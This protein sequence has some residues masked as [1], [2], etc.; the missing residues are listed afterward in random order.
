MS[1]CKSK[2]TECEDS[3]AKRMSFKQEQGLGSLEGRRGLREDWLKTSL[4]QVS[5]KGC[6][7]N[8][9]SFFFFFLILNPMAEKFPAASIIFSLSQTTHTDFFNGTVPSFRIPTQNTERHVWNVLHSLWS[10]CFE[11]CHFP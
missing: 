4:P 1:V 7:F 3:L 6:C 11:S 5:S 8:S 10:C 9:S 2:R